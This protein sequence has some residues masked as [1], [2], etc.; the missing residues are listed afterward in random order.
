MTDL[1]II[2][3]TEQAAGVRG[4]TASGAALD[5]LLLADGVTWVLPVAVLADPEHASRH[6]ALSGLPQ[7]QIAVQEWP[8]DLEIPA[9]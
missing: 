2:L 8:A 7:R 9:S 5:P 4:A 6:G 3:D 1:H